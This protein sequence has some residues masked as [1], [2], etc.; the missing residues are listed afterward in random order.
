MQLVERRMRARY[1]YDFV[2]ALQQM[3]GDCLANSYKIE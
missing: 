1:G 3:V 2:V